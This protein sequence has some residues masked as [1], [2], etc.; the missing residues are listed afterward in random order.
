MTDLIERN[1][2]QINRTQGLAS[3]KQNAVWTENGRTTLAPTARPFRVE[4]PGYSASYDT[5]DKAMENVEFMNKATGSDKFRFVPAGIDT[6][7]QVDTS[8]VTQPGF[9]IV[10]DGFRVKAPKGYAN[11][12]IVE[13]DHSVTYRFE[14]PNTVTEDDATKD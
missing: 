14:L 3:S 11:I 6:G 9:R 1:K 7:T 5:K 10:D 2:G 8:V 13:I 4:G 12:P